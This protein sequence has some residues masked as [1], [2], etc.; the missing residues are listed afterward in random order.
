MTIQGQQTKQRI[1]EAAVDLFSKSGYSEV[2]TRDIAAAAGITEGAIY[3]HYAG[4]AVILD[5]IL[6][7]YQERSEYFL[8][9]KDQIDKHIEALT[10][11]EFLAYCAGYYSEEDMDFVA[12]AF[13][14][15]CREHLISQKAYEIISNQTY[16]RLAE[17]IKYALDLLVQRGSIPRLDTAPFALVWAQAKLSVGQRWALSY[18]DKDTLEQVIIDY[19]VIVKW[20]IEVAL[21][22]RALL[23]TDVHEEIPEASV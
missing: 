4:K 3:R 14:I 12:N 11:K 8:M 1:F 23:E 15:L 16:T 9:T 18:Y 21:T 17:N 13:R 10:T 5:D 2:T 6:D 7:K 22:G 19:K 20:M